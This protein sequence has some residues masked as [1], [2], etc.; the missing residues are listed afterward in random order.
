LSAQIDNAVDMPALLAAPYFAA[1]SSFSAYPIVRAVI[2]GGAIVMACVTILPCR[3]HG[4]SRLATQ[5]PGEIGKTP[6]QL[7]LRLFAVG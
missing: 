5:N 7:S 1:A 2:H 6:R 3:R 4:T